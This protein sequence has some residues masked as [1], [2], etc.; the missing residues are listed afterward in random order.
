MRIVDIL[1]FL[2]TE[3]TS[4]YHFCINYIRKHVKHKG[5]DIEIEASK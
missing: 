4:Y 3:Y 2:N 1:I 5:I